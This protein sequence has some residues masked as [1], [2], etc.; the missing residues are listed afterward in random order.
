MPRAFRV[1]PTPTWRLGLGQIGSQS[2]PLSMTATADRLIVVMADRSVTAVDARSRAVRWRRDRSQLGITPRLVVARDQASM[3]ILGEPSEPLVVIRTSDGTELSRWPH[4]GPLPYQS[5]CFL[6]HASLFTTVDSGPPL[7][8]HDSAGVLLGRMHLPWPGMARSH[9]LL[10]QLLLA[11][12][13]LGTR[14]VGALPV[15]NGIAAFSDRGA[16]WTA[17]YRE[18]FRSPRVQVRTSR[19]AGGTI[20]TESSLES[21]ARAARDLAA[22]DDVIYVAFDGTTELAGRIVDMYRLASGAYVATLRFDQAVRGIAASSRRLYVAG[23]DS[24]Y[25]VVFAYDLSR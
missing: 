7:H 14:C 5:A 17:F 1:P 23:Y 16:L 18:Q 8:V 15:G 4:T 11:G 2:L 12:N 6:R 9:P 22:G 19:R 3:A 24:G 20:I 10:K 21:R 13:G 25:P